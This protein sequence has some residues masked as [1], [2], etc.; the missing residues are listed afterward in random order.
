MD[1][2]PW[3]HKESDTT[4]QLRMRTHTCTYMIHECAC[5]RIYLCTHTCAQSL[6]RLVTQS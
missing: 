3:D 1:Y 6:V 5:V 2:S 4:E